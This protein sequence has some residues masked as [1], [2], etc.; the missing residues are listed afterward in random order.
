MNY[1]QSR[2]PQFL[3]CTT[4]DEATDASRLTIYPHRFILFNTGVLFELLDEG[5]D[6]FSA[7]IFNFFGCVWHESLTK[8]PTSIPPLDEFWQSRLCVRTHQI[9]PQNH[10]LQYWCPFWMAAFVLLFFIWCLVFIFIDFYFFDNYIF[11]QIILMVAFLLLLPH[12]RNY[13][14]CNKIR[15][16]SLISSLQHPTSQ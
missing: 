7:F 9:P 3:H 14:N 2:Q 1:W 15:W 11:S 6:W 8:S 4:F 13:Y 5:G 10:S 12:D 16:H